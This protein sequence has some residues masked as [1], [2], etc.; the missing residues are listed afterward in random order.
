M[1]KLSQNIS[2][3]KY[4]TFNVEA[5]AAYFYEF[6][7][8]GELKTFVE[9]NRDEIRSKNPEILILG[10]GSNYL[11]TRDIKGIVIYPKLTGMRVLKEDENY[12]SVQVEAGE[13]WDDFVDFSVKN[14]YGGIE[15][16]SGIPGKVG[17]VPVQNIGA[18]G[19]EVSE[20]IERVNTLHIDSGEL[21]V[22]QNEEC[23]F[24]YRSSIFK[25]KY[26]DKYVV[27]SVV[28]KL[29]K[30]PQ[31]QLNYKGLTEEL[32]NYEELNLSNIRHAVLNIR[33]RKLPDINK[34]G[35]AGSFFK[36]P[37]ISKKEAQKLRTHYPDLMSFS[38]D[39]DNEKIPAGWLIE[40]AGY[41][42]AHA[43]DAGVYDKQ[44]VVI[45]NYGNTDGLTIYHLAQEVQQSVYNKF[46]IYL[47]P[48]V[49]II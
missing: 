13:T 42:G 7:Q 10:G 23:E 47:E 38:V 31:F 34:T 8:P 22:F 9:G 29:N 12:V 39:T 41:K 19:M 18:Y 21:R 11:F 46:G 49:T 24:A 40:K 25:T 48:E 2:L 6:T 5:T 14:G 36:N 33:S 37:V 16:L 27:L 32:A 43:G 20:S 26:R 17:A 3:K 1:E 44:A 15:N 4:N 35:N 45:V 30:H 28:F